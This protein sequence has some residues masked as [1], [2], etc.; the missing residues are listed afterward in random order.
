MLETIR[1]RTL[2]YQWRFTFEVSFV[3]GLLLLRQ[4]AVEVSHSQSIWNRLMGRR[5]LRQVIDLL[6]TDKSRY[7]AL[8]RPIIVLSFGHRVCFLSAISRKS[9]R[10][11]EK[12][13]I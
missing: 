10:K 3:C 13:V 12:R 6:A 2:G 9:G 5:G 1:I 11:K 4:Q 7:F 8:S